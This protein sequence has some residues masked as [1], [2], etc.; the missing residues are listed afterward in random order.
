MILQLEERGCILSRSAPHKE[1][2]QRWRVPLET[3]GILGRMKLKPA[4][5]RNKRAFYFCGG[6]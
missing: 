2:E 4:D 1:Q 3:L 5:P 6:V